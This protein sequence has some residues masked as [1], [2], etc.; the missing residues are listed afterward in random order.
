MAMC[1]YGLDTDVEAQGDLPRRVP[2]GQKLEDFALAVGERRAVGAAVRLGR[3]AQVGLD[4]L[5][6]HGRAQVGLAGG[7][8]ADR[9]DE[10]FARAVFQQVAARAGSLAGSRWTLLR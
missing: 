9:R 7:G 6:G 3:L 5:I 8:R 10:L 1:L 4:D 2:L